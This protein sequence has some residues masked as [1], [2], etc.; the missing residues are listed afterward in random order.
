MAGRGK[1]VDRSSCRDEV[2]SAGGLDP[3]RSK[4]AGDQ[5]ERPFLSDP[6]KRAD[7]PVPAALA[8]A[9]LEMGLTV[10]GLTLGGWW[11]DGRWGTRPWLMLVGLAVALVGSTYNVWKIGRSFFDD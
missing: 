10:A 4:E 1:A 7:K 3:D 6:P 9:G 5:E 8:G 2:S 11:L